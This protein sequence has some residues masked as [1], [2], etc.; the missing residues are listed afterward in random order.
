M[1]VGHSPRMS[2][3]TNHSLSLKNTKATIYLATDGF[4]DQL[5][6]SKH[7]KYGSV[8]LKKGII[9]NSMKPFA[10]QQ[11]ILHNAFDSWMGSSF[12]V[13]DVTILGIK[14]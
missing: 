7:S 13:D 5:G 3:F 11:E 14:I 9:S 8:K 12:Q 1:P 2:A 10:E 4:A 6:G